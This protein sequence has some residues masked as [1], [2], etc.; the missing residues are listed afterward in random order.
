MLEVILRFVCHL[1]FVSSVGVK[2]VM[3]I[4][5]KKRGVLS[6]WALGLIDMD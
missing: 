5:L 3:M 1:L 6:G 4:V 2:L